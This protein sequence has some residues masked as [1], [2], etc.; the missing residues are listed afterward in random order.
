MKN[1]LVILNSR[2]VVITGKLC[3]QTSFEMPFISNRF[4]NALNT[5][6]KTRLD[7]N[8]CRNTYT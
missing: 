6:V 4:W 2:M 1:L 8:P 5:E 3:Y 7:S